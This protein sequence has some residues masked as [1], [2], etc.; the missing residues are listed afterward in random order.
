MGVVPLRY[1]QYMHV[2]IFGSRMKQ[3]D[4]YQGMQ[5]DSWQRDHARIK[6]IM[7]DGQQRHVGLLKHRQEVTRAMPWD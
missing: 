7:S 4:E 1:N 6:G 5:V 2:S 3:G